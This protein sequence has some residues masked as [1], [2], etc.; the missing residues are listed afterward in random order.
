MAREEFKCNISETQLGSWV[1]ALEKQRDEIVSM[2]GE[3]R[4][5]ATSSA[6]MRRRIDACKAVTADIIKVAYERILCIENFNADHVR[7]RLWEIAKCSYAHP[8]YVSAVSQASHS[9]PN[10]SSYS[11]SSLVAKRIEAAAEFAAKEAEYEV[12]LKEE[13]Q[14][15]IM[16]AQTSAGSLTN[17]KGFK[18]GSC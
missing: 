11:K 16:N 17:R 12:L 10:T 9:A 13:K 15:D 2:Y 8:I 3:L 1:D 4:K 7:S 14:R 6:E 18:N 5:S